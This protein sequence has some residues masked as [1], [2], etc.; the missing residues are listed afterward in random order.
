MP[1]L[2]CTVQEANF[3]VKNLVI[4][5]C[6]LGFNFGVKGLIALKFVLPSGKGKAIPLQFL[7]V[8]GV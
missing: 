8:P 3:P 4:H 6:E 5:R 2:T 1:I 7:R